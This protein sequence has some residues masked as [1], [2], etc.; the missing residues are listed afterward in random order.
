MGLDE[1]ASARAQ[2]KAGE[3]VEGEYRP[4]EPV[5]KRRRP[6]LAAAVSR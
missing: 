6:G 3:V 2:V 4:D 1:S 5:H